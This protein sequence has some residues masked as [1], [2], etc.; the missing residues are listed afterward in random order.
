M[1][2]THIN[3]QEAHARIQTHPDMVILD[4][5]TPDE[6]EMFFIL[7]AVNIDCLHRSFKRKLALLGKDTEYLVHCHMGGRS[8]PALEIFKELG[9]KNIVHMD[10]G[11]RAWNEE[12]LPVISNWSI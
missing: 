6:F 4:L 11:M 9:F 10:G 5:R 2:I 12:E 7:G 8:L 1:H 3:A